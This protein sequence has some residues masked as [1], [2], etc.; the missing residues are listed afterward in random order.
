MGKGRSKKVPNAKSTRSSTRTSSSPYARPRPRNATN[1]I[2]DDNGAKVTRPT[3]STVVNGNDDVSYVDTDTAN[4]VNNETPIL[5]LGDPGNVFNAS[6]IEGPVNFDCGLTP[7]IAADDSQQ[8]SGTV[9]STVINTPD[10]VESTHSILGCNVPL[11]TRQKICQ[12]EYVDLALMLRTTT[13][14]PE[15]PLSISHTGELISKEKISSKILDI[16]KWTNAF[17]IFMSIYISA[18][19]CK[20]QDL[21]KYMRS[22]RLGASRSRGMGWKFRLRKAADPTSSWGNVD[23]ELWLIYMANNT[24]N[25]KFQTANKF[26][27]GFSTTGK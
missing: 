17:I 25:P 20:S 2:Q 1:N 24:N 23:Y 13:K 12:G 15:R 3:T 21:L 16:E 14:E 18:H 6:N 27:S 4:N 11:S 7:L 22:V 8:N 9:I 19:P 5:P 10:P 26:H